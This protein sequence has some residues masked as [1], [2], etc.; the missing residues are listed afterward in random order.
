ML[1]NDRTEIIETFSSQRFVAWLIDDRLLIYDKA[2]N[3]CEMVNALG[4]LLFLL[5]ADQPSTYATLLDN[6]SQLAPHLPKQNT[7]V[8]LC[9]KQWQKRGWLQMTADN[10]YTL[11]QQITNSTVLPRGISAQLPSVGQV[12][13][14]DNL[15]KRIWVN[16][17]GQDVIA[18]SFYQVLQHP[19]CPEAIPRLLAVLQGVMVAAPA[20]STHVKFSLS[21]VVNEAQVVI[22]TEAFCYTITD[23]SYALSMLATLLLRLSYADAGMMLSAH[24]AAIGKAGKQILLPANSGSGKS[25]LTATLLAQG[26]EYYGDDVVALAALKD[27]AMQTLPFRTAVGL[28]PGAWSLLSALYPILP[29]LAVTEYAGKQAKFLPLSQSASSAWQTGRIQAVV[30][31]RFSSASLPSLRPLTLSET[32]ATF[33][34]S[35]VSF[36]QDSP[37][38]TANLTQWLAWL[39]QTP[40]YEMVFNDSASAE[41]MLE[42]LL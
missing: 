24:A 40:C 23:E 39:Q 32:I 34:I 35:G 5:L 13:M 7:H 25:T 2:E 41:Q 29:S 15:V 36:M 37:D 28:K 11:S 27:N 31:P 42:T 10:N 4:S 9:L 16:L 17:N 33:L 30:F 18:V 8:S 1:A 19:F 22:C 14:T 21:F 38:K 6:I 3:Q 26:W 20:S 12:L